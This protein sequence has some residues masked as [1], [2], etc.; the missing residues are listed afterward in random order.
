MVIRDLCGLELLDKK[1]HGRGGG[2]NMPHCHWLTG[3]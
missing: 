3:R 1:A 2:L